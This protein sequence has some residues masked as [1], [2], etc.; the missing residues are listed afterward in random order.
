[1]ILYECGTCGMCLNARVR[2]WAE[3]RWERFL[4][5]LSVVEVNKKG[6]WIW[7][8]GLTQSQMMRLL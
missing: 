2:K 8:G 6:E 3:E 1:M 5:V 4:E 7:P